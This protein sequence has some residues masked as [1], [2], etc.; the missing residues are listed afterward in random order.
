MDFSY[1][2]KNMLTLM[3]EIGGIGVIICG[4]ASFLAKHWSNYYMEKTKDKYQK[5]F[6]EIKQGYDKEL[7]EIKSKFDN[8]LFISNMQYEK[9]FKIYQEIW[10]ALIECDNAFKVNYSIIKKIDKNDPLRVDRDNAIKF[11]A[12]YGN[13]L[14][15]IRKNEP[16]YDDAIYDDLLQLCMCYG[17]KLRLNDFYITTKYRSKDYINWYLSDNR[18]D[19]TDELIKK[20]KKEIKDYMKNLKIKLF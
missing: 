10:D 13:F 16:F 20:I 7:T 11:S 9:E 6:A 2:A 1:I 5:E 19:Y 4:F 14:M 17:S 8:L 12:A 18:F 3:G 15:K